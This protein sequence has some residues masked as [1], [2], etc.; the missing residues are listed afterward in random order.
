VEA[1]EEY[2]EAVS[3][4]IYFIIL[5]PY[6]NSWIFLEFAIDIDVEDYSDNYRQS[7]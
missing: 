3:E 7:E 6:G 5:F 2:G 1:A 4:S